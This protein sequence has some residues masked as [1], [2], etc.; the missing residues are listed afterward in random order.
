MEDT[1]TSKKLVG[2]FVC[3]DAFFKSSLTTGWLIS[4]HQEGK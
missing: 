2:V 4:S 3:Q 1:D